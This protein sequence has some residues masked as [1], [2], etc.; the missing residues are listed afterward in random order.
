MLFQNTSGELLFLK[1]QAKTKYNFVTNLLKLCMLY[2]L[3]GVGV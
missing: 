3:H 2:Q 1:K